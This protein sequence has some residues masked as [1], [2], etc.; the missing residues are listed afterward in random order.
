MSHQRKE[1]IAS[2]NISQ[3]VKQFLQLIP[4][5][6]PRQR[7]NLNAEAGRR[8]YLLIS[9]P[10]DINKEKQWCRHWTQNCL[11]FIV[12]SIQ[13]T[14]PSDVWMVNSEWTHFLMCSNY[15]FQGHKW[16]PAKRVLTV[17]LHRERMQINSHQ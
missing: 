10:S 13:I 7:R 9:R 3:A 17:F 11:Q 16:T 4:V 6:S 2:S 15:N 14:W 5:E 1:S 12:G 8:L